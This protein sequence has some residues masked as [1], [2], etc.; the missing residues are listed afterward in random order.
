MYVHQRKSI[1]AVMVKQRQYTHVHA[2]ARTLCTKG[3]AR[4]HYD[5]HT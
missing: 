2:H 1:R 3:R 4:M 5:I